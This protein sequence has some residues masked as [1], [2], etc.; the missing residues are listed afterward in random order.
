MK[1][2]RSLS[3][4]TGPRHGQGVLTDRLDQK[5]RPLNDYCCDTPCLFQT[6]SGRVAPVFSVVRFKDR[7]VQYTVQKPVRHATY[8]VMCFPV[9]LSHEFALLQKK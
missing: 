1:K 9:G 6:I 2:A 7:T 5:P 3:R 8:L 4:S